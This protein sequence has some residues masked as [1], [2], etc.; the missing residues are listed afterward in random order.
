MDGNVP[1]E[2]K[3]EAEAL[4]TQIADLQGRWDTEQRAEGDAEARA[5]GM[6]GTGDGEAAEVRQLRG[7]VNLADY[8]AP[9][10]SGAAIS[11][12]AGE[13]NAALG[14]P[15]AGPGGGVAVPWAALLGAE[16]EPLARGVRNPRAAFTDTGD[17]DGPQ[18]DRPILQRLFGPG[19]LD[20]LG[21]RVDAVPTGS[22]RV[23][24]N[25]V[26]HHGRRRSRGHRGRGGRG[27][28]VHHRRSEA[29]KV[30][31]ADSS[32]PTKWPRACRRWKWR[33]GATWRTAS[34]RR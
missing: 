17:H 11:G 8:L 14:V 28:S 19:I 31:P 9:A 6:I 29:E 21:V 20:Q 3:A 26:R 32:S 12:A 1:A 34:R 22:I 10:S 27:G 25:H 7:R 5:L 30:N 18:V 2:R 23:A 13:F 33:C 15:M 24:D 4:R 16:H